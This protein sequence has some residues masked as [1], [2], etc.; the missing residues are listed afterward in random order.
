[1]NLQPT[2]IEDT[3][4]IRPLQKE[5]FDNLYLVAS[6]KLLWEQHPNNDR[7]KKEVFEDFFQKALD[8]KG[9]FVIIDQNSNEIIGS[10]RFYDYDEKLKTIV[11][12]Y[13]FIARKYW[14]THYNRS[15]KKMMMD[16]AF[17]DID[18]I[19]FYV[20][21]TNYRSQKAM[22]KLGGK[23]IG[24]TTAS[25]GVEENPVYEIT[26]QTWLNK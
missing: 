20:G 4:L 6:D 5:D 25:N 26:K 1:M 12:G 13:T 22:E 24:Y 17:N 10:S 15:I 14:G 7:Y 8:S 21:K 23:I 2:L 9:A 3:I 11:I 19:Q 18:K 16:Y